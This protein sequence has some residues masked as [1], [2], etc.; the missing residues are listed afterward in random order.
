MMRPAM[1]L[2]STPTAKES[3]K[4]GGVFERTVA[5]MFDNFLANLGFAI[6]LGIAFRLLLTS[7]FYR[8]LDL[9]VPRTEIAYRMSL[10]LRTMWDTMYTFFDKLRVVLLFVIFPSWAWS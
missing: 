9:I 10:D 4:Y 2:Y 7:G 3:E 1:H 5:W 8:T 6:L